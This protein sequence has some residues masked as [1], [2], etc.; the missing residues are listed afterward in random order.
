M[1]CVWDFGGNRQS[2]FV[3]IQ[4][5]EEG[6]LYAEACAE[7]LPCNHHKQEKH[8]YGSIFGTAV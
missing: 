5:N 8:G 2:V 7:G 1:P 3:G 6:V 4:S